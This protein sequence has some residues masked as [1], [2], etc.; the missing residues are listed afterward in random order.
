MTVH[1]VSINSI[2]L[3]YD[4]EGSGKPIVFLH[5]ARSSAVSWEAIIPH[6][7]GDYT[8]FVLDQR[9]HGRSA[10]LPTADYNLDAFAGECA[11]FLAQVTGPAV[12]VGH[13]QGGHAA[14]G[15]AVRRSDL[16]R[17]HLR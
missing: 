7:M 15:A 3:K 16:V 10:R 9:G 2:D 14:F 4:Q 11:E 8:C 6:F 17:S 13:S 1:S 12:L 5:G